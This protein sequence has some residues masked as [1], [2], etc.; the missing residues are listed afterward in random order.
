MPESPN[1]TLSHTASL[2]FSCDLS[3][4]IREHGLS[5]TDRTLSHMASLAQI[6]LSRAR[7]ATVAVKSSETGP[8]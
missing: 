2:T 5:H 4:P 7:E 1:Q 8:E 3:H 6:G